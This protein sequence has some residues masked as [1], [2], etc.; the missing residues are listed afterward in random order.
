MRKSGFFAKS[1]SLQEGGGGFAATGKRGRTHSRPRDV[2]TKVMIPQPI[3][4][5]L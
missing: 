2:T 5:T 4:V 1:K 3:N